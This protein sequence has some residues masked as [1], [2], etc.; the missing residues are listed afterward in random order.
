MKILLVF[1]VGTAISWTT[2]VW[3]MSLEETNIINNGDYVI[4]FLNKADASEY[5]K[6]ADFYNRMNDYMDASIR[7]EEDLSLNEPEKNDE[8]ADV[9]ASQKT[10]EPTDE[11]P[12]KA[13]T[14]YT[15]IEIESE[16]SGDEMA[17]AADEIFLGE[18]SF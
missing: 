3:S 7:L 17:K 4:I 1:I 14:K 8:Q 13:D 15:Q 6:D 5:M 12:E 10:N 11:E 2:M 9:E 18:N 16:A